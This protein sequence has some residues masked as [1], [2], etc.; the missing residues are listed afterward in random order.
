MGMDHSKYWIEQAEY[1]LGTARAMQRTGRYLYVGFMCQLTLEKALKAVIAKQG[2]FPPKTH[3]LAKLAKLANL[4]DSLTE[5]Q[6]RLIDVLY[7]LNIEARYPSHK[8]K[9]AQA[10]DKGTC[11]KF[12]TDTKAML[13]WIKE[14]L[15]I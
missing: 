5:E 11:K 4:T 9:L 8:E 13:E 10:L 3:D 12:L 7:P 6:Q 14:K 1:D 2:D 15:A